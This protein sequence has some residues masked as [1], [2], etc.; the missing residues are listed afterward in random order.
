[1]EE[2]GTNK[3][4]R[5]ERG[6][7]MNEE[8]GREREEKKGKTERKQDEEWREEGGRGTREAKGSHREKLGKKTVLAPNGTMNNEDKIVYLFMR[9]Q[10]K[11][12]HL[13]TVPKLQQEKTIKPFLGM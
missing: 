9:G 10:E 5:E 4:K 3:G 7:E 11:F 8:G 13:R 12:G 6:R 1:M 2:E